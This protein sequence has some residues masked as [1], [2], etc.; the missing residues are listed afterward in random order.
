MF[1]IKN[2][3]TPEIHLTTANFKNRELYRSSFLKSEF[4]QQLII[5]DRYIN[6]GD[7]FWRLVTDW[8]HCKSHQYEKRIYQRN[9]FVSEISKLSSSKSH[10][11]C[12]PQHSSLVNGGVSEFCLKSRSKLVSFRPHDVDHIVVLSFLKTVCLSSKL[13]MIFN[14]T[15]PSIKTTNILIVEIKLNWTWNDLCMVWFIP[16]SFWV[17][18]VIFDRAN[19]A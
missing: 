3:R 13:S 11:H 5:V 9:D 12:H 19:P 4:Y 7:G 17:H 6:V 2:T 15:W 18:S 14:Q 1:K 16:N 10:Q 8:A